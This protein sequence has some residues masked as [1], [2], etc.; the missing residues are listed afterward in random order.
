M[1]LF[2]YFL[3][4]VIFI[5]ALA[6]RKKMMEHTIGAIHRGA[7][8]LNNRVESWMKRQIETNPYSPYARIAMRKRFERLRIMRDLYRKWSEKEKKENPDDSSN[9]PQNAFSNDSLSNAGDVGGADGDFVGARRNPVI[10]RRKPSHEHVE[11]AFPREIAVR[12]ETGPA[13]AGHPEF[14]GETGR[15]VSP[16]G[17]SS[18]EGFPVGGVELLPLKARESFGWLPCSDDGPDDGAVYGPKGNE[19]PEELKK[20]RQ[21][22]VPNAPGKYPSIIPMYGAWEMTERG[23][24]LRAYDIISNTPASAAYQVFRN[25]RGEVF[26]R[27][28]EQERVP[29][30]ETGLPEAGHGMPSHVEAE[31]SSPKRRSPAYPGGSDISGDPRKT[32]S[33]DTSSAETVALE[34]ASGESLGPTTPRQTHQQEPQ[35]TF[36]QVPQPTPQPPLQQAHLSG[37]GASQP[38]HFSETSQIIQAAKPP[39][40]VADRQDVSSPKAVPRLPAQH[41]PS[42]PD[43]DSPGSG[44]A[45]KRRPLPRKYPPGS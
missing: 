41:H 31:F 16:A 45:L 36:Q 44:S 3:L 18:Q 19:V 11:E 13:E 26:A 6:F 32:G 4:I 7:L 1:L 25:K 20:P 9:S 23:P 34:A 35:Q 15:A 40:A 39:R 2:K 10:F 17:T 22:F 24:A 12:T 21:Y 38:V 29:H 14:S 33:S 30:A 27:K 5:A 43:S 42:P 8:T 28:I 37:S